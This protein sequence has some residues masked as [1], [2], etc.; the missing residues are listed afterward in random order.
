MQIQTN[1]KNII[2][3]FG[4]VLLNIDYNLTIAGFKKLGLNHFEKYYS[5]AEQND[6]FDK[7]E[8]GNINPQEFREELK[9]QII[10]NCT[11]EEIDYAWNAMLL[12]LPKERLE[13]LNSIRTKY[14]IFLLSNTNKIHHAAFSSSLKIKFNKDIFSDLFEKAYFSHE[15]KMRK[16]NAE[17]FEF[18]LNENNLKPEETL[19]IDDSIQHI[20]GAKKL[21]LQTI[22][23]KKGES[24]LSY[25]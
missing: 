18:V 8:T 13:L 11:D 14:R 1:I 25:F 21:G 23:L 19:F 15:V 24:I 5:Q 2:F 4:G 3:D 17:I 7:H 16:P 12:D 9:K 20:E 6:L 10:N 22:F